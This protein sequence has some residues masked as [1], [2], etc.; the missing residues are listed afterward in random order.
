MNV[1]DSYFH[2]SLKNKFRDHN[3]YFSTAWSPLPLP[4]Q[5]LVF[6]QDIL[7]HTYLEAPIRPL[8]TSLYNQIRKIL[9]E[10]WLGESVELLPLNTLVILYHYPQTPGLEQDLRYTLHPSH[11][12]TPPAFITDPYPSLTLTQGY[13]SSPVFFLTRCIDIRNRHNKRSP[14]THILLLKLTIIWKIREYISS[15]KIH[16][17]NSDFPNKNWLKTRRHRTKNKNKAK[18]AKL[19]K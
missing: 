2:T 18:S 1:L 10:F 19:I 5:P 4:S 7:S 3:Q 11:L 6:F 9:Y 17:S 16:L 13:T 15:S 8:T 14:H 12:C